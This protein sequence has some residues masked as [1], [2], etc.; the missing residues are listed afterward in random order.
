MP[1][2]NAPIF[3]G[4][5]GV[6]K[7]R[8]A[9]RALS[10][11]QLY[12]VPGR[13]PVWR[14]SGASRRLFAGPRDSQIASTVPRSVLAGPVPVLE[15]DLC[16]G[17]WQFSGN[18]RWGGPASGPVGQPPDKVVVSFQAGRCRGG[19]DG[20]LGGI[21]GREG[22]VSRLGRS[23]SVEAGLR[24][25]PPTSCGAVFCG[26]SVRVPP[27]PDVQ[28]RSCSHGAKRATWESAPTATQAG[29][30]PYSSW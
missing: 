28:S 3:C 10:L 29:A 14:V 11:R 13:P 18:R 15:R 7:D 30:D 20:R 19:L 12:A 25:R 6:R 22:P 23:N 21:A 26:C 17:G 9:C 5:A 4:Q 8:L 27:R 16:P 1:P 24:G 2:E